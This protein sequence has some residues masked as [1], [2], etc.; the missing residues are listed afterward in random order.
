MNATSLGMGDG[1]TPFD[2]SRLAPGQVVADIVYHPSPTTLVAGAR[3]RGMVAVD[4][5]GMLVHQAGHSFRLWTGQEPPIAAM[6]EAATGALG[7][8]N[9]ESH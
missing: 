4:G 8:R 1:G 6:S 7:A 9:P 2:P 3:Q 5:L